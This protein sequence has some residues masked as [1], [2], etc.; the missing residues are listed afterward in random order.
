MQEIKLVGLDQSVFYK[1]LKN[2]LSVYFIPYKNKTNYTM[3]YITKFGS[4]NTT[5]KS[6]D[7]KKMITVPDGIAHFLEHKM[8]EQE[9]GIDPFT[10][11]AKT[12]TSANASTSQK[13]TRYYFEGNS[14][15]EENLE[16]LI[17]YV[18]SPYFTDENV[19]KE[20]GIIAEEINQY[21][22]EVEW[23]LD[24]EIK[25]AI[26]KN[27]PS[28]IDIGGT[29]ESITSITKEQLYETYHTFYQPSNMI[30][31]I[32]GDFNL[33]KA[34]EL[35]ENNELL[36]N[37]KTNIE[38]EEKFEKEPI[39]VFKKECNL[40]FNI[41]N[42]KMAYTIKIPLKDIKD[43]YLF[44]LYIGLFSSIKFGLSSEF[45]ENMRKKNLMTSFYT[46]REI[47]GDFLLMTFIADSENPKEL[48]SEIKK[49]LNSINIK[50][51]DVE[52]LKKVWISSEV[53]MIDNISL[54]LD[55]ILYDIINYGKVINNKTEIFRTLNLSDLE[56]TVKEI[57]FSNASVII[58]NPKKV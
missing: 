44:N 7:S 9:D 3:H 27:E 43:K 40:E 26:F 19:E 58:V 47:Y 32:C 8:F 25:Q 12:G 22:D 4:R 23:F 13:I 52:R 46:E 39:E 33:E 29:V 20:K 42:T 36:N 10:F 11:A 57:D 31:M 21:D 38:I 1:K 16:Y 51:E 50:E 37:V 14:G 18:H 48:V 45:R 2:G 35:I 28:R 56:N 24:N 6:I 34:L 41:I 53:V 5:F 55:N 30:L 54:T 15:F 49:E 17:N